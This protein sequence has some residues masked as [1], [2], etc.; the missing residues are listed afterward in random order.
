MTRVIGFMNVVE[1]R[2]AAD[3]D[4]AD[5]AH[6]RPQLEPVGQVAEL[7]LGE[8]D[9][10]AVVDRALLGL[11]LRVPGEQAFRR[12]RGCCRRSTCRGSAPS[13]PP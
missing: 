7:G 3:L 1:D 12:S 9:P 10:G 6:A 5:D 8:L 4:V 11:S 13:I 2:A